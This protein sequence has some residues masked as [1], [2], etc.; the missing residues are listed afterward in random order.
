MGESRRPRSVV[1]SGGGTGIGL[2]T[3][4]TMAADGD[5]VLILGRRPETL[6]KAAAEVND[7]LG[8]ERVRWHSAD[9]T[10]PAQYL[11]LVEAVTAS[12]EHVD[13][14]VNNAGGRYGGDPVGLASIAEAWQS[15]FVGNVLP[16]VLL[17]Q[18]LRPM[19]RRP[20]GRVIAV[21]SIAA[22]RSTGGSYGA[23]K[24]ALHVWAH[25]LTSELGPDGI[26]VN[27]I[28]P[29][30]VPETEFFPD[31]VTEDFHRSRIDATPVGRAGT[32]EEMAAAIRYLASSQAGFTT[33]QIL[34]VNGGMLFGRG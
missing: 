3:A 12:D 14:L 33:G 13:V 32:P 15:D 20:G 19:L 16:T 6:K 22:F 28:A 2:A 10:D 5:R 27:V 4:R 11:G 31:G 23:A 29:G 26:T 25:S 7:E 24:A 9:L 34:H 18:A 8:A 30:Y 1:I 21:G 17:T